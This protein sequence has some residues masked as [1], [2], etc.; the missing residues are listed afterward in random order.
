MENPIPNIGP[1][2]G[3]ISIAP[4]TTALELTFNPIDAIRIENTNIHAVCP[5][6]EIP[7]L[8]VL[9]VASLSVPVLIL[10]SFGKYS[11]KLW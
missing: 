8:I 4:I 11:F 2:K 9:A 10:K 3:D 1:I 6:M 7:S 5:L